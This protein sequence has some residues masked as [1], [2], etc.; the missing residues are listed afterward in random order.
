MRADYD[1]FARFGGSML[2]TAVSLTTFLP[3]VLAFRATELGA[4]TTAWVFALL[5]FASSALWSSLTGS[6]PLDGRLAV[7]C[8]TATSLWIGLY[9]TRWIV[10]RRRTRN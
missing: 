4:N 9:A 8:V 2:L 5:G 6:A 10:E 3:F 7:Y 1:L